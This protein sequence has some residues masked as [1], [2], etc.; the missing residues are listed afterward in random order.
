MFRRGSFSFNTRGPNTISLE[1]IGTIDVAAECA[2]GSLP[3]A[4]DKVR[5]MLELKNDGGEDA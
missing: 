2:T 1:L 5:D 3:Q 4:M